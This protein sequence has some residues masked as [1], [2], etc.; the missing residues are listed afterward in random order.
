MKQWKTLKKETILDHGK[1]LK[2]EEHTIKLPDGKIIEKW[3]WV[4]S[5][6]FVL[7]MPVTDKKTV[8]CFQQTKYAIKGTTLAPVAG[9]IDPGENPL[10]AAKREM[11]EEIGYKSYEWINLGS[12]IQCGNKGAG[13]GHLF[14]AKDIKKVS[15]KK[16]DDLEEQKLIELSIDELKTALLKKKFKV[17]SWSHLF[18]LGILYL[19]Y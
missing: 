6:D 1:Y 10:S 15:K 7:V 4:I 17:G 8:F 16:S 19:N 13:T 9:M 5:N 12:Y 2:V 14:I 11:E 3:P 18:S